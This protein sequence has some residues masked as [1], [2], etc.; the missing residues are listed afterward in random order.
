[1]LAR[2]GSICY[3]CGPLLRLW[4][5]T[6]RDMLR[7]TSRIQLDEREVEERFI[8]ASGPGGQNVNKTST[9]VQ[10]RFDAA[11]SPS[12]PE[13]VR[14]RLLRLGGARVDKRGV[15]TIEARRYRDQSRNRDDALERLVKLVRKAA[16]PPVPRRRTTPSP[17][18]RQRR[19]DDKR[20]RG[21]LKKARRPDPAE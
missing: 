5:R 11:G 1:M 4:P 8:R 14:Q 3:T 9:A 18:S 12:L 15:L 7:I 16:E 6:L 13:A 17:A 10:L 19:L 20:R 2:R 21:E